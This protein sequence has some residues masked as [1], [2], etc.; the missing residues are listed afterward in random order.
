MI[1]DSSHFLLAI[2]VVLVFGITLR[3]RERQISRKLDRTGKKI[4]ARVIK[5][6]VAWWNRSF[7]RYIVYEYIV[8]GKTHRQQQVINRRQFKKLRS[9]ESVAVLYLEDDPFVSKIE[10]QP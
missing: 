6:Y 9:K 1:M 4:D 3:W 10:E 7:P 8:G 2:A 5:I